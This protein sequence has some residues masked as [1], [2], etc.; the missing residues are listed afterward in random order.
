MEAVGSLPAPRVPRAS[1]WING[2]CAV[3]FERIHGAMVCAQWPEGALSAAEQQAI[4]FHSLPDTMSLELR[5]NNSIRDSSYFFRVP[6]SECGNGGLSGASSGGASGD[7]S[8]G[9]SRSGGAQREGAAAQPFL[10]CYVF[11]RQRQDSRL[12]RGGEQT[13]VVVTSEQPFGSALMPLAQAA[14]P[15]YFSAGPAALR[16]VY[17]QVC[18]WAPPLPGSAMQLSVPAASAAI[19][20]RCPSFASLPPPQ[21]QVEASAQA[22]LSRRMSR[23]SGLLRGALSSGG[24]LASAPSLAPAPAEASVASASSVDLTQADGGGGGGGGANGG[25]ERGSGGWAAP[26]GGGGGDSLPQL[27]SGGPFFAQAAGAL[28][29]AGA[30]GGAGA[31]R[32]RLQVAGSSGLG[33]HR[34]LSWPALVSAGGEDKQNGAFG[35]VDIPRALQRCVHHAWALWEKALSGEPLLALAPTPGEAAD[36]VAAVVSLI[37][38][39]PYCADFRPY[40]CI[41]DAAFGALLEEQRRRAHGAARRG[42]ACG[43][44]LGAAPAACGNAA[45]AG[46]A[47]AGPG[48][49]G[50]A[51]GGGGGGG[52]GGGPERPGAVGMTR[53]GAA[54]PALFGVTNT[55]F[56]TSLPDFP[57][58]LS[59]G[60]KEGAPRPPGGAALLYPPNALR[61][62]RRRQQGAAALVGAHSQGLWAAGRPLVAADAALL[63]ATPAA[64]S[65]ASARHLR[66]HFWELT[67]TFLAPFQRYFEPGPAGTVPRWD[68]AAF[69]SS[70]QLPAAASAAPQPP[71]APPGAAAAC[72]VDPLLAARV[73]GGL[74]AL[75]T[76]YGRFLSGPNFAPWFLSRRRGVEHL[77]LPERPSLAASA[78]AAAAAAGGGVGGE[79][80]GVEEYIAA[81]AALL[82]RLGAL[83]R[84]RTPAEGGGSG[85]GDA[86]AAAAAAAAA[87]A[88]ADPEAAALSRR[89]AAAFWALGSED[90]QQTLL[91]SAQR[92]ALLAALAARSPA[93]ARA[94]ARL[95]EGLGPRQQ[96]GGGGGGDGDGAG[97]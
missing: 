22:A 45:P 97:S 10:Y 40:L 50:G 79:V 2:I 75:R 28:D 88:E 59:V 89:A 19:S 87:A 34:S 25:G 57:N 86:E 83:G 14:G 21:P 61:A 91:S 42:A 35:E 43:A 26:G 29:A 84:A 72:A 33:A 94:I 41:H 53:R 18:A 37:A 90:L 64:P 4:A 73:P 39:L 32:Q 7:G 70:L 17:D 49:G 81:E 36:A 80:G 55:H 38:P 69:I 16:L 68:P 82:A 13:S 27:G 9:G 58:V 67:A 30:L 44:A 62:L 63:P 65:A 52:G 92:R 51:D 76:L 74:P 56:L 48:G 85:G 47:A 31:A 66:R 78:A 8:G 15:L 6:R 54:A 77:V 71:P 11:C 3:V 60:D 1:P 5:S 20:A 95:V 12:P 96:S 93:E 46:G 24:S 23:R